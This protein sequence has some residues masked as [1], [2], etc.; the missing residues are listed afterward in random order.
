LTWRA[1]VYSAAT[2]SEARL[3]AHLGSVGSRGTLDPREAV[4][5]DGAA[6]RD[7]EAQVDVERHEDEHQRQT[8]PQLDEVQQ[9]LQPVHRTQQPRRPVYTGSTA[10]LIYT[11]CAVPRN[12]RRILVRG[13]NAPL[14][15]EAKKM[16]KI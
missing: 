7:G 5:A 14:P 1:L 9:R 16:L 10:P 2:G 4:V 11:N 8:Q 15:P 12:V 13:V 6:E 3:V